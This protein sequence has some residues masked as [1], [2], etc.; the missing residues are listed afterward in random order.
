MVVQ[1]EDGYI[2]KLVNRVEDKKNGYKLTYEAEL[3]EGRNEQQRHTRTSRPQCHR[4]RL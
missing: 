3:V 1:P 4:S 2:M